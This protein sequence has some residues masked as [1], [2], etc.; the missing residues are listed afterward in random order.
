MFSTKE[1]LETQQAAELANALM[2]FVEVANHG[3]FQ[4]K[5]AAAVVEQTLDR[6][7]AFQV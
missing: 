6:F 1:D 4:I 3:F 5:F 2:E 7:W